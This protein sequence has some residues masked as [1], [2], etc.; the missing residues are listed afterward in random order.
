MACVLLQCSLQGV[1]TKPPIERARDAWRDQDGVEAAWP[2]RIPYDGAGR[3]RRREC[4][5]RSPTSTI[6]TSS[7]TSGRDHYAAYPAAYPT[8]TRAYERGSDWQGQRRPQ[9][10]A[11]GDRAVRTAARRASESAGLAHDP[12]TIADLYY[13]LEDFNRR[14]SSTRRSSNASYDELTGG[15][16]AAPIAYKVR[17]RGKSRCRCTS[18]WRHRLRIGGA[19]RA[20]ESERGT[21]MFRFDER[22]DARRIDE[23]SEAGR[24]EADRELEKQ[25]ACTDAPRS[26][27]RR[28]RRG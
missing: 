4:A 28:G 20:R 21:D 1:A 5:L 7:S 9:E 27:G 12:S 14:T 22:C 24:R 26:T 15:P 2:T 6:T 8:G 17:S 19:P 11:R 18:A 23:A 16:L 25:R 13:R 3:R 10:S